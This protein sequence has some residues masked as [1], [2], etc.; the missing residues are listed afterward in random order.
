MVFRSSDPLV[1][2]DVDGIV[3]NESAPAPN[4]AGVAANVAVLVGT[5]QRGPT[6]LTEI[7]SAQMAV[8]VFG[9][10]NSKGL[11]K[12]LKNKSFGKLKFIRVVAA[13][14]V[15]ATKTFDASS[16]DAIKFTAK[17][18]GA[19]GNLITVKIENGTLTNTKKYTITDTNPN[20]VLTNEV[21]DNV[22]L[23]DLAVK[24]VFAKSALIT[25]T[26]L[27]ASAEPDNT[28]GAEVLAGGDNG[29]IAD[30]DYEDAIEKAQVEGA[31][32]IIF[33]DEYN[34]ARNLLLKNHVALT[35]DKIAICAGLES[36][37][38]TAAVAAVASLRDTEGRIIYSYPYAETVIDGETVVQPTA[39]W[40]ASL[41]SQTNPS[42]DP[43]FTANSKYLGSMIRLNK[44]LN[45]NEY[46]TLKEAGI[47][48]FEYDADLGHKVKS[49]IV[50]QILDSEKVTI[51]RRRMTDFLTVSVAKFLKNYQ[52]AV[53]S[54]QNRTFVKAA[55]ETFDASLEAAGILPKDSEM[56]SGEKAKLIDTESLNTSASIAQGFFKILYKRRIY[57]SMRYIVLN[58]E[59]GQSVVVKEGGQ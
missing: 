33:L 39:Y 17:F 3:V 40:L 24:N 27:S 55:I 10:D 56:Q 18:L 22:K 47:C 20:A 36:D 11:N 41:I 7:T 8:E 32:N 59:I 34:A 26:V 49:G 46:I 58:A 15:K 28:T 9:K 12:V 38:V 37:D 30:T 5:A 52:N 44:S 35:Q 48:A 42:V 19:Y 16:T 1:W 50:T 54:K 25:A 2:D 57:S 21:Y 23:A 6:D 4:V 45:R 13:A 53:N 31:G 43:A 29:T 51:L 14:A